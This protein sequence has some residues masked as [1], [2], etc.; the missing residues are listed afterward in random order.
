M[1]VFPSFKSG[2]LVKYQI[3]VALLY[4]VMFVHT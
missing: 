3:G 1:E 4:G 2:C